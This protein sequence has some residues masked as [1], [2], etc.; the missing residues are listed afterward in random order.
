[1]LIGVLIGFAIPL[2][3]FFLS[4]NETSVDPDGFF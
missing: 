4:R 1:M 2:L 3:I